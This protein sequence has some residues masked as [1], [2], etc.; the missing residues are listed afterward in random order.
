MKGHQEAQLTEGGAGVAYGV[1][2]AV[3]E[4]CSKPEGN[5]LSGDLQECD[6]CSVLVA[7]NGL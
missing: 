3:R 7:V 6:L 4:L 5:Q 1:G 2:A